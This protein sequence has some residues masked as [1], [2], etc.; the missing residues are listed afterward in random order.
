MIFQRVDR[1]EI[2]PRHPEKAVDF[3]VNI[4]GF[5]ITSRME[6][7]MPPMKGGIYLQLG[8]T[9]IPKHPFP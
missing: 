2:A 6:V 4:L 8:G 5:G 9:V 1:V 3:Y 7:K